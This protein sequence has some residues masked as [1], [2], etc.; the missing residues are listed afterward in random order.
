MKPLGR[1]KALRLIGLQ[2][3]FSE[4]VTFCSQKDRTYRISTLISQL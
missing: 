2:L 4:F 3:T 1:E